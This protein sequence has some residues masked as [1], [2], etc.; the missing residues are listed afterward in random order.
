[1]ARRKLP[2]PIQM[3]VVLKGDQRLAENVILEVRA[4]AKRHGLEIPSVRVVHRR[5]VGPKI[6]KPTSCD[7][8]ASRS[9]RKPSV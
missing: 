4:I 5:A 3:N 7:A 6:A 8:R 2:A 1:V 9:R